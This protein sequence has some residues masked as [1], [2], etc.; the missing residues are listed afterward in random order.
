ML[1][2]CEPN[3]KNVDVS[4][5]LLRGPAWFIIRTERS[6][7]GLVGGAVV[8]AIQAYAPAASYL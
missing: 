4:V 3:F 8:G 6:Q 7:V 1:G 5:R 2:M